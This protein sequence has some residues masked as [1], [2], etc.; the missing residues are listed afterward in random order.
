MTDTTVQ[1]A[2]HSSEP[3]LEASSTPSS[4]PINAGHMVATGS[5][6]AL[7]AGVLVW[8]TNWPLKPLDASTA[9]D[10]AGL[11]VAALAGLVAF[12]KSRWPGKPAS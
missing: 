9:A 5:T 2:S 6:T 1:S 12:V 4:R 7:L 11:I 3:A 10:L 8:I